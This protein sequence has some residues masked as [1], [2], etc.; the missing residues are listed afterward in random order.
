MQRRHFLFAAL[1]TPLVIGTGVTAISHLRTFDL[2]MLLTQLQQLRGK[3]LHSTGQWSASEIFQHCTQSIQGS[4]TGYPLAFSPL[5]QHSVGPAA[6][7]VFRSAGAMRHNLA[8]MIPGATPLDTQL[9][10]H[11]ALDNL[12]NTLSQ[13][14]Q[15]EGQLAAH[16]AYGELDKT[17]YS[18]AHYLHI[19]NHL[20]EIN[21]QS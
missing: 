11:T 17:A 15:Y 19:E 5:F 1:A 13:F 3:N 10:A 12:I 6:L 16:F 18:A 2:Q 4:L 7:A 14:M 21:V 20:R 8:E 9:N